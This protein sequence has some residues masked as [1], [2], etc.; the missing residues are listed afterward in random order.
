M[1]ELTGLLPGPS[2]GRVGSVCDSPHHT[3]LPSILLA[4]VQSLVNK[5]DDLMAR[6]KFQYNI[7]DL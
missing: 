4:N 7:R 5:L 6:V 1:T 3:P 2:A